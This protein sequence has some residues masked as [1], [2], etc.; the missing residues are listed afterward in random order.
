MRDVQLGASADIAHASGFMRA[1]AKVHVLPQFYVLNIP[2]PSA[3][4]V[5]VLLTRVHH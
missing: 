1:A 3:A 5:R 2:L 4:D